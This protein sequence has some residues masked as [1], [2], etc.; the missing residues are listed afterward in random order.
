MFWQGSFWLYILPAGILYQILIYRQVHFP[1]RPQVIAGHYKPHGIIR[2][3]YIKQFGTINCSR[4][5]VSHYV[6]I[7]QLTGQLPAAQV[8][9][10][11]SLKCHFNIA[12]VAND[13]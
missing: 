5:V 1:Y 10:T 9:E 8:T 4:T 11:A 13:I 12:F 3:G 2:G 6:A 7:E